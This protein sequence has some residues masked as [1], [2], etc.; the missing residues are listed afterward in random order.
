MGEQMSE[1][2]VAELNQNKKDY[3]A[4]EHAQADRNSKEAYDEQQRQAS[5]AR[6]ETNESAE[7]IAEG[8][9]K[10]RE[11]K[12][13]QKKN[14]EEQE[15]RER[16]KAERDAHTAAQ[17][18]KE[19]RKADMRK[20]RERSHDQEPPGNTAGSRMKT[21]AEQVE[22]SERRVAR[23]NREKEVRAGRTGN[24]PLTA[25]E[26]GWVEDEVRQ[27]AVRIKADRKEWEAQGRPSAEKSTYFKQTSTATQVKDKL[28]GRTPWVNDLLDPLAPKKKEVK[29][30]NTLLGGLA[31]KS[32]ERLGKAGQGFF[33][34]LKRPV[35]G[36]QAGRQKRNTKAETI[37]DPF[38]AL[39]QSQQQARQR[40]H[41]P[42]EGTGMLSSEGFFN[43]LA[44][45]VKK[46]G[47]KGRKTG[48][49]PKSEL[50]FDLGSIF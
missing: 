15:E 2:R 14:Y 8:R 30:I 50:D 34:E 12:E 9:R 24:T 37:E 3:E 28:M 32:K 33:E 5:L 45:P 38:R 41:R 23:A 1:E 18:R 11:D 40:R 31:F 22:E 10:Y 49:K 29:P 48:R 27:S 43:V 19:S 42:R 17:E 20:E 35:A 21:R 44:T 4:R 16:I 7:R 47:K 26:K 36:I 46:G 6:Q 39:T 25:E 13:A